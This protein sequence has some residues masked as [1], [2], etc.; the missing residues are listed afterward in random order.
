MPVKCSHQRHQHLPV[1]AL[2]E[3]FDHGFGV[4]DHFRRI[5]LSSQNGV[6]STSSKHASTMGN[7]GDASVVCRYPLKDKDQQQYQVVSIVR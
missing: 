3:D 4:S 7:G 6:G 1:W 2:G 5:N